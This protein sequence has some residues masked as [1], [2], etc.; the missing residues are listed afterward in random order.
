[1]RKLSFIS[2]VLLLCIVA[3]LTAQDAASNTGW[4]IEQRCVG[5]P[6]SPP[7]DWKYDG[8]IFMRDFPRGIRAVNAESSESYFVLFE[9]KF[10]DGAA[11]SPDGRWYAVPSGTTSP[12]TESGNDLYYDV[13]EIRLYSTDERR[14]LRTIPWEMTFRSSVRPIQW[15]DNEVIIYPIGHHYGG[16]E[17]YKVQIADAEKTVFPLL[18]QYQIEPESQNIF[19]SP[20]WKRLFVFM[21][22][23]EMAKY[24]L[25]DFSKNERITDFFKDDFTGVKAMIAWNSASTYFSL[26]IT[27]EKAKSKDNLYSLQLYTRDGQ[28]IDT[29]MVGSRILHP[30]F[31]PDGDYLAWF[32]DSF[33]VADL[34]NH[35]IVDYCLSNMRNGGFAWS[36]DGKKIVFTDSKQLFVF[37]L[38]T[39]Q[40]YALPSISVG[41]SISLIAWRTLLEN[42]S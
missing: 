35:M 27:E 32:S 12:A 26:S 15:F 25:Y 9:D 19:P 4:P 16:Y 39:V 8:T 23:A 5:D 38:E 1:M 18:E 42:N 40:F 30:A 29:V 21:P 10:I 14:E 17:L 11:L 7:D 37:D 24:F 2:I 22:S 13:K 33:Y 31:S 36:P 20:D 28:L 34:N 41:N 6:T 3:P